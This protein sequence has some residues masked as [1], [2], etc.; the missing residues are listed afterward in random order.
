MSVG[1][2]H[3]NVQKRVLVEALLPLC[4]FLLIDG[5]RAE[6]DV[7][8]SLKIS[9]L[10]LRI[11][12]DPS[13]MGMPDLVLD[14]EGWRAT[15]SLRGVQYQVKVPWEACT[16][17]WVGRPFAGPLIEWPPEKQPEQ[18]PE[19]PKPGGLRLVKT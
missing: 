1:I 17:C 12:R 13:V 18:L 5:T 6:V 19:K 14:D 10:V 8:E 11:G 15:I 3:F 16:R 7:P 2:A 9:E 4:P